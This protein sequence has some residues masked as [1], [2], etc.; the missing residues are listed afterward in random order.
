MRLAPCGATW[1]SAR[2][3]P[4]RGKSQGAACGPTDQVQNHYS[5]Y[6]GSTAPG[7]SAGGGTGRSL[8]RAGHVSSARTSHRFFPPERRG[9]LRSDSARDGITRPNP[10]LR[11][12]RSHPQL[13]LAHRATHGTT[14]ARH[15]HVPSGTALGRR[16]GRLPG[17]TQRDRHLRPPLPRTTAGLLP[18][19]PGPTS[20]GG[21][22]QQKR[23]RPR[24]TSAPAVPV[25]HLQADTPFSALAPAACRPIPADGRENSCVATFAPTSA[26]PPRAPVL[27]RRC[28]CRL[29]ENP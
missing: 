1:K 13:E 6:A 23:L 21:F 8:D 22:G 29:G 20:S 17:R 9:W 16:H 27:Y 11:H 5:A 19:A 25:A 12:H 26:S 18:A 10:R 14:T 2:R 7:V 15:C 4:V 3:A 24:R 28:R